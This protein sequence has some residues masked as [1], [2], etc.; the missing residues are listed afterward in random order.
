MLCATI[1]VTSFVANQSERGPSELPVHATLNRKATHAPALCQFRFTA[2]ISCSA[3]GTVT[4]P[5]PLPYSGQVIISLQ[6]RSSPANAIAYWRWED[7]ADHLSSHIRI[8]TRP[9]VNSCTVSY[10]AILMLPSDPV[11]RSEA[12]AFSR[13]LAP[14]KIVNSRQFSV[15]KVAAGLSKRFPDREDYCEQVAMWV[16]SNR[17]SSLK[18]DRQS[19]QFA[20]E[21]GGG[22]FARANLCAALLRAQKIPAR[23]VAYMPTAASG[24]CPIL[25][26]VEFASEDGNW[27]TVDPTLGLRHPAR[28]ST[29]V[30]AIISPEEEEQIRPELAFAGVE[31]SGGVKWSDA[32]PAALECVMHLLKTFPSKSDPLVMPA[33]YRRSILVIKSAKMGSE[34]SLSLPSLLHATAV[35]PDSVAALLDDR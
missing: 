5:A 15:R 16:A 18:A 24:N 28:N 11:L 33:G 26:L 12:K 3:S 19:A 30:L 31:T 25:W 1:L 17:P 27:V 21:K 7:A 14:T 34:E 22:S 6:V 8:H 9:S 4:L 2:A 20:L 29:V 23:T 10:T 13:W 32:H 35:G